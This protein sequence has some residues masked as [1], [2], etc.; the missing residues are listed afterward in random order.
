[1]RSH[2]FL[3]LLLSL[4]A[5]AP[6]KPPRSDGGVTVGRIFPA[7]S[8]LVNA[9]TAETSAMEREKAGP[10]VA[11]AV[12]VGRRE[13]PRAIRLEFDRPMKTFSGSLPLGALPEPLVVESNLEGLVASWVNGRV[14]EV[15]P[16]GTWPNATLVELRLVSAESRGGLRLQAK[17]TQSFVTNPLRVVSGPSSRNYPNAFYGENGIKLQT[18]L[19]LTPEE[20]A[21][22]LSVTSSLDD[23]KPPQPEAFEVI[24]KESPT[25]FFVTLKNPPRYERIYEFRVSK[26]LS[27]PY[28]VPLDEDWVTYVKG[29]SRLAVSGIY[30]NWGGCPPG[31]PWTVSFLGPVSQDSVARCISTRPR[32]DLGTMTVEGWSVTFTPKGA[33]VGQTYTVLVDRSCRDIH[34]EPMLSGFESTIEVQPPYP[35][36]AMVTGTGFLTPNPK[37]EILIRAAHTGPLKVALAR[38]DRSALPRFLK[39]NLDTWG[40]LSLL[41]IDAQHTMTLPPTHQSKMISLP[42]ETALREGVGLV[43][44]KVETD[45]PPSTDEPL[46]Q[47]AIVQV[48]DLSITAKTSPSDTLVWVTSLS[49]RTPLSDV[50]VEAI[51]ADGEVIWK[52]QT[53]AT[54]LAVGPVTLTNEGSSKSARVI[55]ASRGEDLAFI[56]L[57]NWEIK[58]EP[59]SFNLPYEWDAVADHLRGI[60]FTERGVYRAGETVHVKGYLRLDRGRALESLVGETVQVN[61]RD[62]LGEVVLTRELVIGAANDFELELPLGAKANLGSWDITAKVSKSTRAVGST[63]RVEAYR[64]NTFEVKVGEL[65]VS[66]VKGQ[67]RLDTDI[68]GRYFHGATMVDS[69]VRWWLTSAQADIAPVGFETYSFGVSTW[70]D[71]WWE[72]S[73]RSVQTLASGTGNLDDKGRL[74][75]ETAIAPA[76][77]TQPGEAVEPTSEPH[78]DSPAPRLLTLEAQ[79]SD[80]DAQAVT[81]RSTVRVESSDHYFGL[82]LSTTFAGVDEPI[83]VDA[84]AVTASGTSVKA[85]ATLKWIR[86]TWKSERTPSAGGGF[87]W[88]S[89]THDEM[90]ENR[91]IEIGDTSRIASLR[92]PKAGTYIVELAGEDAQGSSIRTRREVWVWGGHASWMNENDNIVGIIA[93]RSQWKVGETARFVVQSPFD[94]ADALITIERN[95]HLT[96]EVKRLTGRAPLI[97]LPV[98]EDMQPNAYLSVVLLG[99]SDRGPEG[100]ARLGYAQILVDTEDRR[101]SVSVSPEASEYRP[102]DKVRAA[103]VVKNAKGEPVSGEVAFMAVDEGV[104]SLTGYK[105]PDPHAAFH[106]ARPLTVSNYEARRL[107]WRERTIEE[108]KSDW[109][110]GGEGG[111]STNYRSA[112]ATTAAF[113]PDVPVGPDGLASVE[114][115]LPDNLTTFRLMA[116]A[117]SSDGRFGSGESK[118]I[119][120]RP[121]M[122]RPGLPRFI[123]VGDTFDARAIVQAVAPDLIASERELVVDLK[124]SGPVSLEGNSSASL[125]A[126]SKATPVQ[127]RVKANA[128]GQATFAFRV[129]GGSVSDAFEVSLPVQWPATLKSAWEA[130]TLSPESESESFELQIPNWVHGAVGG[131]E[132]TVSTSRFGELLPGL[133]YLLNYPY[134]CVEQTTGGTLP[135]V[136]LRELEQGFSLPGISSDAILTR[137]QAGIDRILSMQTWTGGLAYWPGESN[138]HPWGSVYGGLALV[139]ASRIPGLNV[140]KEALDR[141]KSYLDTIMTGEAVAAQDEWRTEL[142]VTKPFAAWLL[143][144]MGHSNPSS[145]AS[146]FANH[147][148][149]PDFAKLMLAL[150]IDESKGEASMVKTLLDAVSTRVTLEGERAF[151]KRDSDRYYHST[152]DSDAR[153][154]ALL[155][156]A[157]ERVRPNDPLL[158][159]LVYGLL[160]TRERGEW[161]TTQDNAFA[162]LALSR[163]FVRTESNLEPTTV[164][165][166]IGDRKD[167]STFES[168]RTVAHVLEIPMQDLKALLG[169]PLQ[170]RREKGQSPVYWSLRFNYADEKPPRLDQTAGFTVTRS[171]LYASGDKKGQPVTD[172]R[173][174]DLVLVTLDIDTPE[175]RRY[176]AVDDPLPAGLEAVTLDFSTTSDFEAGLVDSPS[177]YS[178]FNHKEQRDDRVLLFADWMPA[179]AHSHQYLARATT[180]GAFFAAPTHVSEMYH[181]NVYGLSTGRDL[182]VQ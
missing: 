46:S 138:P 10:L 179:G 131:L 129:V 121:L 182:S 176:V 165:I 64:P 67:K 21:R 89:S 42:L 100:K 124:V 9:S 30:C 80:V 175:D 146:L 95:G 16:S 114:F 12:V 77:V 61:I 78:I 140:R 20:L 169:K 48:T 153:N 113:M 180:S 105:T 83:D 51:S 152:M 112:F 47:S 171:Y 170:I 102:G 19:A 109:G 81:G 149:M 122:I 157:M 130:G 164:V 126:S 36:L 58:T 26:A 4:V 104:L 7:T 143:A 96:R 40:G 65:V 145:L 97:E 94:V 57:N 22:H 111:E 156:L 60:V 155:I 34:G 52:G 39:K 92:A 160:S 17:V 177:Y 56:D 172:L 8:Q 106:K 75:L 14:V 50:E 32:L 68:E 119:S 141:L 125:K 174:G 84:V 142:D 1:M 2:L 35:E 107:L 3:G 86:R 93:E 6:S 79:I 98:T 158:P 168:A 44:V 88:R 33:K 73:G 25:E 148:T 108:V 139:T 161:A 103:I 49:E 11:K 144:L 137:A 5:C 136:A 166:D 59:Y 101:L 128:P 134:G 87:E 115:T 63:F 167:T 24:K 27:G 66:N 117:A 45:D 85:R 99:A 178:S 13:S 54:G 70:D 31:R 147:T 43:H 55:V 91:D 135:L 163:H 118:V 37:A 23:D 116:V 29:P 127:F 53:D 74:H 90:L 41:E 181:P 123:S 159:K 110:G 150:A 162:I 28:P 82:K 72:P 38:I 76:L 62:P 173:A 154:Q 132:V 133:G 18:S 69:P 120:N 15:V 71:N 151:L